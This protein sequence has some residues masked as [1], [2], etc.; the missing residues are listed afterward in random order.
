MK[1]YKSL[2]L[3]ILLAIINDCFSQSTDEITNK[4]VDIV[5]WINNFEDNNSPEQI[6]QGTLQDKVHVEYNQGILTIYSM[7]WQG[8]HEPNMIIREIV[9]LKDISR[10]EALEKNNGNNVIV[11]IAIHVQ[12][13]SI[14]LECKN[15]NDY[16]FHR[17]DF[18]DKWYD[19]IGFCSRNLRFKFP[20]E[21]ASEQI[22]RV[23]KAL[24]ELAIINGGKPKIGSMF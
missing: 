3:F 23:Y 16:Q 4:S 12:K 1:N 21:S 13:E 17:C 10:I 6:M 9:K 15:D 24:N 5:R 7:I 8:S 11:D 14:S 18:E 19:K 20:K 2:L 22:E